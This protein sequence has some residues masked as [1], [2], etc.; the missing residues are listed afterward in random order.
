[1]KRVGLCAATE[2]GYY[3]LLQT[4]KTGRKDLLAWVSSFQEVNVTKSWDEEIITLSKEYG[5]PYYSWKEVKRFEG[6]KEK[7]SAIVTIGWRYLL[8]KHLYGDLENGLIVFHDS[9]LPKYRGF[10]PT[11]TAM[12]C[13]EKKVGVSVLHGEKEMDKGDLIFQEAVEIAERDKIADV[14]EK[15]KVIYGELLLKVLD[16]VQSGYLPAKAQ[17]ESM[18]TYSVW[19][20]TEDCRID[21]NLDAEEI[22]L[23]IRAVGSPYPGAYYF[24]DGEKVIVDE[25]EIVPDASFAIRT[26]G[27]VWKLEDGCPTVICGRNMLKIVKA[28]D[29]SGKKVCFKR[30]RS[31]FT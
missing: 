25:A 10:A 18:A 22:D 6:N 3:A 8:P 31:R 1:M 29:E 30:L 11:V 7:L 16:G 20:D 13:G 23:L 26:P 19:R 2:K 9:L 15:E 4:V 5:I 12:L 24:F 14:I 28:H 27:K 17:D 21:W